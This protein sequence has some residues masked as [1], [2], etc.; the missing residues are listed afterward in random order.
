[1]ESKDLI[2]VENVYLQRRKRMGHALKRLTLRFFALII[3]ACVLGVLIF[4]LP[5]IREK[6]ISLVGGKIPQIEAPSG[7][8][9]EKENEEENVKEP[10]NNEE[11]PPSTEV[12]VPSG[13]YEI[14]SVKTQYSVVNEAGIS[15]EF[16]APSLI[17]P[18]KISKKY[19]SEAPVILITHLQPKESYSN[20]KYYTESDNFYSDTENVASLAKELTSKLNSLGIKTIYLEDEYA[21]GSVFGARLE[22]EKSLDKVLSEYPSIS[23]VFSLSRGIY[24][25]DDMSQ[26]SEKITQEGKSCAQI[27]IISGASG[28]ST[29]PLQEKNVA[30]SLDFARFSNEKFDNFVCQSVI[31]HF[32]LSQ[33]IAP[34]S[35]E[36]ELG[37]YAS[38]YKEASESTSLLAQLIF[39]YFSV[40]EAP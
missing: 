20:G 19:G 25:N 24:V 31:S 13:A 14:T 28:E 1:M 10:E 36:V 38:T 33:N 11:T 3:L 7:T 40:A 34:F 2:L 9:G 22:Y 35:C 30:F 21:K 26:N 8:V 18:T 23:Y 6:F 4:T 29:T 17:L 15:L 12:S 37:S 32:P 5:S 16:G 27:R 39:E